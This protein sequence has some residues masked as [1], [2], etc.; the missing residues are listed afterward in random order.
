MTGS[1]MFFESMLL[2]NY[3]I[4]LFIFFSHIVK[5]SVFIEITFILCV[6][7]FYILH[8]GSYHY[9]GGN[10]KACDWT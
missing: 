8:E 1:L 7:S 3:R 9:I 6:N 10:L 5:I 2:L 4:P